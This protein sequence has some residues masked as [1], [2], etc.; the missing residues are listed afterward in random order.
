MIYTSYFSK[1]KELE[2][3]HIYPIAICGKSPD[4]YKGSEYKKLAP[5]WSI[6]SEWKQNQD[7]E[8]YTRRF[9]N[10]ILNTLNPNGIMR[11]LVAMSDEIHIGLLCY[12]KS[13]SFCH[14][15]LVANWLREN[16]IDVEEFSGNIR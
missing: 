15:H 9:N 14:R 2:K 10:E 16:G 5:S 11:E 4:W 6:F 12:E 7:E 3:H 13:D 1:L 8:L